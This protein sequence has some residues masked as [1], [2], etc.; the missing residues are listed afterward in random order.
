M[1]FSLPIPAE[2]NELL[3]RDPLALLI[4][5][6]LDQQ[7]KLEKAFTSPYA[8]AHRRRP[9]PTPRP[10]PRRRR[11][12]RLPPGGADRRVRRPARP[13]PVPQGDGRTGAGGLPGAAG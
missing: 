8:L 13:A 10:P 1:P 9:T 7:D 11:A 2:A 4:G 5:M 12:S 6:T 3:D